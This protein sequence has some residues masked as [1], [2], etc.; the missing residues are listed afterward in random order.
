MSEQLPASLAA[1]PN[2]PWEHQTLEQLIEERDYWIKK[3]EDA[4]GWASAYAADGFRKACEAW[5]KLKTQ[6]SKEG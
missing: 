2:I 1:K 6:P 5:I 4:S 3:V